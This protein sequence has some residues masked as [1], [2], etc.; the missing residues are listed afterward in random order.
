MLKFKKMKR[1][2]KDGFTLIE[3]IVS[4]GVFTII[5]LISAGS[6]LIVLGAQKK[7]ISAG[8][9]QENLRITLEMMAKEIRTGTSYYCGSSKD[10]FGSGSDTRDCSVGGLALTFY[11]TNRTLIYRVN[12]QRIEKYIDGNTSLACPVSDPTDDDCFSII[13]FPEVKIDNLTFYV[14]GSDIVSDTAQPKVTIVLKGSMDM[15]SKASESEF[16]IQTTVSQRRLDL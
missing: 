2:K 4:L 6:F 14:T 10:D 13:T 11:F 1:F 12:N 16:N 15:T 9:I 5:A 3:M 7:S 8:N